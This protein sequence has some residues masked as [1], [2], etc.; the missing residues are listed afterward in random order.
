MTVNS[1]S[2]WGSTALG[3]ASFKPKLKT[4]NVRHD[5]FHSAIYLPDCLH[6]LSHAV[7]VHSL[8]DLLISAAE[9]PSASTSP[10]TPSSPSP[11]S[12]ANT[13]LHNPPPPPPPA[14]YKSDQ[15]MRLKIA[16]RENEHPPR[17]RTPLLTDSP[18]ESPVNLNMNIGRN[19]GTVRFLFGPNGGV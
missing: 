6:P 9:N 3:N 4:W 10:S 1:Q 18:R 17:S 12:R 19:E 2:S 11:Y 14:P 7:I 13:N 16:M 5:A 15:L 8:L